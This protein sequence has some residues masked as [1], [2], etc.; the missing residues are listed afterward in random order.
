MPKIDKNLYLHQ[1]T[2][3]DY[4]QFFADG[5]VPV[6]RI[7]CAMYAYKDI[8]GSNE[9]YLG[10]VNMTALYQN[11]LSYV[12]Q[13][14]GNDV[15]LWVYPISKEKFLILD[16]YYLYYDNVSRSVYAQEMTISKEELKEKRFEKCSK[17]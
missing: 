7:M 14:V 11:I 2:I 4:F 3:S 15:I 6:E 12:E 8:I 13:Y 10:H 1:S 9:V 17:S 16:C 5:E